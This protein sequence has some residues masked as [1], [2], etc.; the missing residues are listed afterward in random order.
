MSIKQKTIIL[1]G[2]ICMAVANYSRAGNG[3]NLLPQY[4][5]YEIAENTFNIVENKKSKDIYVDPS[6]WKG[7]RRAVTDLTEDIQ[8]VSGVSAKPNETVSIGQSGIIVGTIG[9]SKII[10]RLIAEKKIDVSSCLLYT[11]DA[12][13]E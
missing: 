13:D 10:D 3:Y 2:V 11:S 5:I 8:R 7:V 9:K 4:G 6:D 1:L 12:A